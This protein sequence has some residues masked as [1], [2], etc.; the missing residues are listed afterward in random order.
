MNVA[1]SCQ[2]SLNPSLS[3]S[4]LGEAHYSSL[5]IICGH[6]ML[7]APKQAS[8]WQSPETDEAETITKG[9]S[10]VD[11]LLPQACVSAVCVCVCCEV[12]T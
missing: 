8:D 1:V 2:D 3:S 7:N 4:F 6:I 12:I 9:T 10:V 5:L 11:P